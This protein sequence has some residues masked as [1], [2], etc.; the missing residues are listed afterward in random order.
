MEDMERPVIKKFLRLFVVAVAVVLVV[1]FS[2][3]LML[4]TR[5]PEVFGIVAVLIIFVGLPAMFVFLIYSAL[6]FQVRLKGM[7][8]ERGEAIIK[9]HSGEE[10]LGCILGRRR[11]G[12]IL[13]YSIVHEVLVITPNE[14]IVE[15]IRTETPQFG[16]GVSVIH[17]DH[18]FVIPESEMKEIKL[19]K[20]LQ[21]NLRIVTREKEYKWWVKSLI[22]ERKG[23][24]LEDYKNLLR[25]AFPDKMSVQKQEE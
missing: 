11:A 17:A 9:E 4:D 24:K 3:Y 8:K 7:E 23:V 15:E 14:V 13:G 10:V 12:S 20:L 16:G 21:V 6:K 1:L 18:K 19:G 22:P 5:P 25:Q 2:I